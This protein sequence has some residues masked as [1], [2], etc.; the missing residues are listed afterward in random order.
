[1]PSASLEIVTE[2]FTK[3]LEAEIQEKVLCHAL[4]MFSRSATFFNNELPKNIVDAF[5]KG[6][7]F[8]STTQLVTVGYL[9]WLS[10]CLENG[11]LGND[12]DL[13]P[14]LLQTVQ[15][16]SQNETNSNCGRSCMC[17]LLI[18]W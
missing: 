1:M 14:L 3:F 11:K 2:H 15:K 10:S 4:E 16:A 7:N 12:V 13:S 18:I 5:K 9:Q 8:K 17:S 6:L